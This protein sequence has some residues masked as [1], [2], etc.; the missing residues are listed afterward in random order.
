MENFDAIYIIKDDGIRLHSKT[1]P[2][3]KKDDDYKFDD[4]I[5]GFFS[6]ISS[7]ADAQLN[8]DGIEYV[9][10]K[11]NRRLYYKDYKIGGHVLHFVILTS[12]IPNN[13]DPINRFIASNSIKIKWML[14]GLANYV[15][16]SRVPSREETDGIDEKIDNLFK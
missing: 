5:T 16:S 15:T 2:K 4:T 9:Q 3:I 12:K 6:A 11:S 8:Q 14:E 1:N 13:T 10:F 7:F